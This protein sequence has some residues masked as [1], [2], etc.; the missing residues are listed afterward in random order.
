[1]VVS[2]SA[3]QAKSYYSDALVQADYY[4]PDDSQEIGGRFQGKLADRLG[5]SGP[6]TRDVFFALCENKQPLT[7]R[8]L[9]PRYREDRRVGYDINFHCPKSV[10]ILNSLVSDNHVLEAFQES[11]RETMAEIETDTKTRV[12]KSGMNGERETG[13]AIWADFTHLT[14]RP[15]DD[16]AP[17]PHLHAHCFLFNMTWDNVEQQFKAG[18]FHDIKMSMPYYQ[19]KFHKRLSDRLVKLGY[20]IERTDKSFEVAGIPKRVIELFSKRTDEI[21][22]IAKEKGITDARELDGLGARTRSAKNKKM[23]LSELK[24]DWKRQM[25]EDMPEAEKSADLIVRHGPAKEIP[26]AEKSHPQQSVDYALKHCFERASVVPYRKLEET[27]LRHCLGDVSVS[28][29]DIAAAMGQDSRIIR[30]R[31]RGR[32]YCTTKD[33]LREEQAMVNLARKGKGQI[34]PLYSKAPALKLEGQQAEA[35]SH[36]LTTTDRVS[37]VRGAAG[38]GKTTLLQ[39]ASKHIEAAGK[40]LIVVAPTAQASRGVLREDGFSEAETVAA[41][42]AKP[43]QQEQLKGNVLWVDEAGLLGTA[44]MRGLLQLADTHNA[45]LILGGDTRQHSAVVR[46]DALR[47]LNT[48]AGIHTAE[49][50]KI[51]RQ[52]DEL[53]RSAVQDLSAGDVQTGF[54]KLD[55]MGSIKNIDPM[56]PHDQLVDDYLKAVKDG[57]T[58]LVISP[59]HAQGDA[60]TDAL[61]QRMRQ[62]R[63]IGQKETSFLSLKNRN[64]T[65][66]EKTDWRNYQPGQVVQFHQNMRG[67]IGRGSRWKVS[68]ADSGAVLLENKA[69]DTIALPTD[70]SGKFELYDAQS[71]GLSKGDRVRITQNGFDAQNERLDNGDMLTVTSVSKKGQATFKKGRGF[72]RYTLGQDFGHIAHAHCVTSHSSQGQTVDMAFVMQPSATF[73]ATDARQFYV[74]ASRARERTLIYTDDK[75]ALLE[76]AA[77]AGDR[78]SALELVRG[79]K[80]TAHQEYV[81]Q[82]QREIQPQ[83]EIDIKPSLPKIDLE[84]Y[85]PR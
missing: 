84:D 59:T 57:K 22:R 19:A 25:R 82:L 2:Q 8:Q 60:V 27:A 61:R 52:K 4:L 42:L 48:V 72:T 54:E 44:D 53:Y 66:A 33:V 18:E 67:G 68:K 3:G 38:T 20:Q 51:H 21:G 73:S 70:Q 6:A 79:S 1:M 26:E 7:G 49:V 43:K 5:L 63:M 85:E 78:P 29:K 41:L 12:R 65:E 16:H 31:E 46:G 56:K 80:N 30:I 64:L 32:E 9:T 13:E 81:A 40:K 24:A 34:S 14:S 55:G 17:D 58:T 75:E 36:I 37:I 69:G 77:E 35:V 15:V 83:M 47:V 74:S 39:E 76:H 23:T 28:E 62:A 11:V 10:S 71:I 50:S 45:Q